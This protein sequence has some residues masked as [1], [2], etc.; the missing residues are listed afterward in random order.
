MKATIP[1]AMAAMS[2]SRLLPR[3]RHNRMTIAP[4]HITIS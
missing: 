3:E 1:I 4:A 2:M